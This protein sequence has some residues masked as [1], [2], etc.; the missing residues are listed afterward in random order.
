MNAKNRKKAYAFIFLTMVLLP[1]TACKKK[2]NNDVLND[3]IYRENYDSV[4]SVIGEN[5]TIDMVEE[6]AD[7]RAYVRYEG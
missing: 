1:F 3:V 7:G 2:G 5:I 4:Y 6:K